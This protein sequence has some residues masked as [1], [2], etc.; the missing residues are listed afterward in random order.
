MLVLH[1]WQSFQSHLSEFAYRFLQ[2]ATASTGLVWNPAENVSFLQVDI[3]VGVEELVR[4]GG[5]WWVKRTGDVGQQVGEFITALVVVFQRSKH[6]PE[7]ACARSRA[8]SP[9]GDL[10]EIYFTAFHLMLRV[11]ACSPIHILLA[12]CDKKHMMQ[13]KSQLSFNFKPYL[14]IFM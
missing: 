10:I 7:C 9:K 12:S 2:D 8:Q 5:D 11:S 3:R 6:T 4:E 1:H 14:D 13:L